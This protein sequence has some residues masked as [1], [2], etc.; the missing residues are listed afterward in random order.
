MFYPAPSDLTLP[1]ADVAPITYDI[2]FLIVLF[3]D[4]LR[5]SLPVLQIGDAQKHLE[6]IWQKGI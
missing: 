6:I 2:S 4:Y 1:L 5:W 3:V